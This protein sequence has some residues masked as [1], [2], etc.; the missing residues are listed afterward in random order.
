[1]TDFLTLTTCFHLS[2]AGVSWAGFEKILFNRQSALKCDT[3][4]LTEKC[5]VLNG[6]LKV[7]QGVFPSLFCWVRITDCSYKME[8]I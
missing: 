6:P 2:V 7:S 8:R 1:M 4:S 3:V 5:E